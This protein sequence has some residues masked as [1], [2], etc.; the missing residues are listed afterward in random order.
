MRG[1]LVRTTRRFWSPPRRT[2]T[3]TRR[4]IGGSAV[5]ISLLALTACGDG[6]D[7]ASSTETMTPKTITADRVLQVSEVHEETGMTLLEGPTFDQDGRLHVVDVTAP[8]G[9]AKVMR[10]DLE[11]SEVEQLYT[12]DTGAYTSTQW[13]RHDDRLY[14]TDYAGGRIISITAEGDDPQ[15]VFEG[16][17]DGRAMHPD[18][19][20]FDKAGN[21]FVTD[22]SPTVYPEAEPSG[23]IVRIDG[24][25]HEATVLA[26]HQPNP[27]G[28]SFT[29]EY[30]ALWISQLDA[31]RIDRLMLD[32][33][34]S[35][36]TVGHTAIHIDGGGA[37]TDSNA[38]D[39]DRNIYQ[40]LHGRPEIRVHADD[41]RSLGTIEIPRDHEGLESATNIAIKPGTTEAYATVSGPGGGFIYRF[42]AFGEGIRQSNGG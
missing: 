41:G 10:I 25:S 6:G 36:V 19:L 24:E 1:A 30:D 11:A 33:D 2:R 7:E 20:T 42:E 13:G 39:A 29:R 12:D 35:K 26:D 21:L 28:I 27:N 17:V 8:A 15:T 32:E 14:L 40:A 4:V 16:K 22:S 31:D 23:R 18:D 9:E 38:V 5:V 37:Q 3:S 34:H